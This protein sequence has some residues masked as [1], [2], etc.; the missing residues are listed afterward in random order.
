M[1][2]PRPG[3]LGALA[4]FVARWPALA[5]LIGGLIAVAIAAARG[6]RGAASA[7]ALAAIMA[8]VVIVVWV[9]LFWMMRRA[10]AGYAM[11]LEPVVRR[12]ERGADGSITWSEAGQPVRQLD[13]PELVLMLREAP[14]HDATGAWP[15]LLIARQDERAPLVL[16]TR[17]S[18]EE[19]RALPMAPEPLRAQIDDKLPPHL[20]SP[21]L[22]LARGAR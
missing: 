18:V 4:R 6:W 15:V 8:L 17:L 20:L 21:W 1:A 14:P 3:A 19:A 7:P 22:Q 11:R 12:L 13:N 10:F 5:G 9:G 16:E 2:R